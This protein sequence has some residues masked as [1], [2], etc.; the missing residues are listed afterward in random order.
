MKLFRR[1]FFGVGLLSIGI[2]S[3]L[4]GLYT[5]QKD[6]VLSEQAAI[7]RAEH[8]TEIPGLN[9]YDE[10]KPA[11]FLNSKIAF[12]GHTFSN[13]KQAAAYYLATNNEYIKRKLYIG[14]KKNIIKDAST[15]EITSVSSLDE[16]DPSRVKPA[17]L[18]SDGTYTED[19]TKAAMELL[20]APEYYTK[21]IN[22]LVYNQNASSVNKPTNDTDKYFRDFYYYQF[23]DY[24]KANFQTVD[25]NPLNYFDIL[26]LKNIAVN[27][28]N[29]NG[30]KYTLSVYDLDK[31]NNQYNKVDN[32]T[33]LNKMF[34]NELSNQLYSV[35]NEF[36]WE[37]LFINIQGT[38][39]NSGKVF[40]IWYGVPYL[41][42]SDDASIE[43]Y[44]PWYLSDAR[45][46]TNQNGAFKDQN[47]FI[48]SILS[49]TDP[50]TF[51][52][53]FKKVEPLVSSFNKTIGW[54]YRD[55]RKSFGFDNGKITLRA[56]GNWVGW[57][58]SPH[59][60]GDNNAGIYSN[61]KFANM[62]ISLNINQS[63]VDKY[64]V[65]KEKIDAL[66]NQLEKIIPSGNQ[67]QKQT[68][69]DSVVGAIQ[70]VLTKNIF[71]GFNINT[72]TSRDDIYTYINTVIANQLTREFTLALTKR[73]ETVN[74]DASKAI[75]QLLGGLFSLN[76]TLNSREKLF[77]IEYN[78]HP[79]FTLNLISDEMF[80]KIFINKYTIELN[81]SALTSMVNALQEYQKQQ[82]TRIGNLLLN[83]SNNISYNPSTHQ[84]VLKPLTDTNQ[85]VKYNAARFDITNLY[86][87]FGL[88]P[89]NQHH[90]Q[91]LTN[92]SDSSK[93]DV[94]TYGVVKA[95]ENSISNDKLINVNDVVIAWNE[96]GTIKPT[97]LAKVS[98]L[99]INP[100]A[101]S[102]K[103]IRYRSELEN[104]IINVGQ[105]TK[106]VMVI[107]NWLG[108]II[109]QEFYD[110]DQLPTEEQIKEKMQA[111]AQ[112]MSLNPSTQ[113]IFDNGTF[114][115]VDNLN[116]IYEINLANN[117]KW[118]NSYQEAFS[119]IARLIQISS[120]RIN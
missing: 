97:K 49:Y 25:I 71:Q 90:A 56:K 87:Q 66:K 79:L 67:N 44:L 85:L 93:T 102:T 42:A 74:T 82:P 20:K 37:N 116:L 41:A 13:E 95:L 86:R 48:N 54:N 31:E 10:Q 16:I 91:L 68:F 40:K 21:S 114:K 62:S 46:N 118:F 69:I 75:E 117:K 15:S 76:D 29:K 101:N 64:Q 112:K 45:V 99:T 83:V 32:A 11:E 103:L 3:T 1:V 38:V 9:G 89:N 61:A 43:Y 36:L 109:A 2:G 58:W 57:G 27:S 70:T 39:N 51:N 104:E 73:N 105:Q 14:D 106:E 26:K 119:Y 60:D 84:V 63:W 47:Q 5:Y 28:L 4:G 12:D 80:K 33:L 34:I 115:H 108:D 17:Y 94:E 53:S 24:S 65:P 8:H 35:I 77:V 96:D 30:T 88:N 98:S 59:L 23:Q 19:Q 18:L 92:P 110:K 55:E 120:V 111:A 81:Q 6:K 72:N 7:Q 22:G 78:N 107:R 52:Q 50:N 100:S 113:Y